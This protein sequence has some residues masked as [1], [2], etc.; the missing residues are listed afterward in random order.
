MN[1]QNFVAALIHGQLG[2]TL[3]N[4]FNR[5]GS[6][7]PFI[8]DP[9]NNKTLVE[10]LA[11]DG[12][13]PPRIGFRIALDVLPESVSSLLAVPPTSAAGL[14]ALLDKARTALGGQT[15][16]FER[17]R[18]A[19]AKLIDAQNPGS[20][21]E[22]AK[23][24]FGG[25]ID[26]S[27]GPGG[28][29]NARSGCV[30]RLHEF[31]GN[32]IGTA[33]PFATIINAVPQALQNTLEIPESVE[34]A[35]LAYFFQPAGYQ[36]VDGERV[37]APVHLS[38]IGSAAVRVVGGSDPGEQLRGLF[39][40]TTAER[41][42]RD[43]TRIIVESAFDA[44]RDLKERYSR[45]ELELKSRKST[46]KDKEAI[47]QKFV[48]W[49]RGFAAMSESASMR[50]VEVGTQGVSQFQTNALIAAAAGSFAGTVARKLA[51]DCFLGVLRN[52][53]DKKKTP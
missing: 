10:Q 30:Q 24:L 35:L 17:Q 5:D 39:P 4:V 44:V 51:Q 21:R 2:Q 16:L 34:R 38:D 43:M 37:V 41:Y 7:N 26:V 25:V 40:Q 18:E 31:L 23:G 47:A 19:I 14:P 48:V 50:A 49:L 11:E 53:L 3:T 46:E 45:I 42:L 52:E 28:I 27:K 8:I 33:L 15:E 36:T 29:D 6:E 22:A 9:G 32:D 12:D 13:N 1:D 20:L